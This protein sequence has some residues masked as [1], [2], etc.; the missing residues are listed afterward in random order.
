MAK[1][2]K[3]MRGYGAKEKKYD[4]PKKEMKMLAD[5]TQSDY[6]YP[7]ATDTEKTDMGRMR[8][9]AVGDKGYARQAFDYDY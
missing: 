5:N 3:E 4:M 1:D 8:Y 9:H 7:I 2:Y 6:V